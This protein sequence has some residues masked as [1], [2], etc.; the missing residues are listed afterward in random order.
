MKMKKLT[1]L[2]LS[3]V[4]AIGLVGCGAGG[5]GSDSALG[6]SADKTGSALTVGI[7]QY[8]SHSSLDEICGALQAELK[9]LETERQKTDPDFQLNVILKNG[10]GDA[11]TLIDS[12][13]LFA[14]EKADLVIAVATPA[15]TTAAASLQGTDTPLVFCAVTDPVA[16]QLVDSMDAPGGRIT[17]TSD[18]IDIEAIFDLAFK[19][20]PNL[21]KMGI[22]YNLSEPNS[23]AT[24]EK[25]I[26]QL[27]SRG[28]SV[29][30]STVSVEGEV[31][32]AVHDLISEGVE[33]I[34]VPIDNTV[35]NA[36][37]V[38]ADEAIAA[39]LPVYTAADS[40]VRDG[41][42]ATAGVNYTE[43]GQKTAQMAFEILA[44]G[45]DPAGMAVQ[46]MEDA[47]ITVNTNTAKALNIDPNIFDCGEGYLTVDSAKQ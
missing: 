21:K 29:I 17:G 7:L 40:L 32:M 46:V 47:R 41:G 25:A 30:T 14:A 8:T 16:A 19:Q 9:E 31:Q 1:A 39:G 6:G 11:A 13:T 28:T 20:N 4:L 18:Y 24:V 37:S 23:V 12:C 38:L 34:F 42:L 33:A 26:P 44:N 45:K 27:E 2:F 15:A 3:F 5:S 36:M 35:A 22:I 43:L 10:Q